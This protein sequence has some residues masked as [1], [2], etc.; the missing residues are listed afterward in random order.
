MKFRQVQW[1]KCKKFNWKANRKSGTAKRCPCAGSKTLS[2]TSWASSVSK[3]FLQLN[4]QISSRSPLVL[5]GLTFI[6]FW[7]KKESKNPQSVLPNLGYMVPF[8][9][10]S[11]CFKSC[12][13]E[14]RELSISQVFAH[15]NVY[16]TLCK[17][18][19]F[20]REKQ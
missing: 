3:N 20:L 15:K 12:F 13:L 10:L 4:K 5:N 16:G 7:Q 19:M 6:K 11:L 1:N 9:F 18:D 14:V 8:R 2:N 17:L